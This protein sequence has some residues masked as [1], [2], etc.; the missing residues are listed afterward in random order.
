MPRAAAAV[1]LAAAVLA[2]APTPGAAAKESP[3]AT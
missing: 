2:L 3:S 1:M